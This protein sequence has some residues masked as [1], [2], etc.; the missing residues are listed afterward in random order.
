MRRFDSLAEI[1][2][3]DFPRGSAVAIGKFDGVHLGHQA[4]LARLLG[5]AD[6]AELDSVVF[7]FSNNPLSLLR[8]ELCPLPL[9]S[10]EQRLAAIESSGVSAC[11][12]VEFD[13]ELSTM[14]AE[15]Y[16]ERVLL[17]R[18]HARH[19]IVG[20]DFR[21][22]HRGAG[23]VALLRRMGE[24]LGFVT[25]VV[26][27]VE[28]PEL[29]RISST[30]VREAI[31]AGDVSLAARML[32]R[33][34]AVRGEVVHG[35]ARG[36]ELGFPTA[37]LGGGVEGLVPA[38]GVYAGRVLLDGRSHDAAISI[39]TNPTFTEGGQSRVEAYLLDFSDDI[40]GARV[41][42]RLLHR[43]RGM[44]KFTSV[45]D[46]VDQMREDVSETRRLLG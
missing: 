33:P 4:I 11:V 2:E 31:L 38:D 30:R 39:G 45:D 25:D 44:E 22:G 43:L 28:D 29:G 9:M 19:L 6:G 13:A 15:E 24:R 12:M 26:G 10:R 41:E 7:T 5:I 27:S 32:G 20:S 14:P 36:R 37:N 18:L 34:V 21:F 40:Y 8:P 23:D 1:R 3:T 46:L 17:D 35:D 42:V 16:V